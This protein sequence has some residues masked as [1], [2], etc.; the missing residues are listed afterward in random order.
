M[1]QVRA[2]VPAS[3]S[4]TAGHTFDRPP[5]ESGGIGDSMRGLM[6]LGHWPFL[7]IATG[8]IAYGIYQFICA[9]YRRIAVR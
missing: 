8:V 6:Q 5:Q 4:R 2:K 1:R 3:C 7:S 9:K